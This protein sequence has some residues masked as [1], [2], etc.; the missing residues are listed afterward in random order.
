MQAGSDLSEGLGAI[1]ALKKNWQFIFL[2]YKNDRAR[3]LLIENI[4]ACEKTKVGNWVVVVG[5]ELNF[6]SL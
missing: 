1:G 5:L 6:S 3:F 2:L 4:G